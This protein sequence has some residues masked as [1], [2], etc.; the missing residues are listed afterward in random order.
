MTVCDHYF[1]Y[2]CIKEMDSFTT[3]GYGFDLE[4]ASQAGGDLQCPLR[5]AICPTKTKMSGPRF[6]LK[7]V[8]QTNAYKERIRC[9]YKAAKQHQL[10]LTQPLDSTDYSA[11]QAAMSKDYRRPRSVGSCSARSAG[12]NSSYGPD[13]IEAMDHRLARLETTIAEE[14]TGRQTV[15]NQLDQLRQLLETHLDK[16]SQKAKAS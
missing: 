16:E 7:T 2:D 3:R 14:R 5:A 1:H 9:E 12:T 4:I 11:F 10:N 13:C 6:D 15:Q 8:P